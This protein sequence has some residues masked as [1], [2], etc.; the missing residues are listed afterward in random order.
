[1]NNLDLTA[2]I[3]ATR[4]IMDRADELLTLVPAE[5]EKGDEPEVPMDRDDVAELADLQ[6]IL[7][8]LCGEGGDE[9]YNGD[10]YPAH[11]IREGHFQSYAQEL[12]ED[13]G[14]VPDDAVWPMTCIDWKQAAREL[15][16]DYTAAEIGKHTYYF[17]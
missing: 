15:Q 13:C 1:M 9:Q 6:A 7:A 5:T 14:M 3:I 11:L 12:A 10:W 17:R 2:D 4:D 16:M 8:D